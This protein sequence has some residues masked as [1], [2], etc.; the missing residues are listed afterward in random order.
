MPTSI[1]AADPVE[2]IRVQMLKFAQRLALSPEYVQDAKF[3][4][5]EDP[6]TGNV[7]AIFYRKIPAVCGPDVRVPYSWW[8]HVKERFL[9][10]YLR[11]RF[12]I[13]YRTYQAREYL[14]EFPIPTYAGPRI[15]S[16]PEISRWDPR[17]DKD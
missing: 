13:R 3:D 12:P 14:P 7:L 8:D 6:L 17:F 9:T 5:F 2:T 15:L 16:F 4:A 11:N 10:G 1:E